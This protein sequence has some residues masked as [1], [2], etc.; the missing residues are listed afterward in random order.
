MFSFFAKLS[1][2]KDPLISVIIPNYNNAPYLEECIDS[3]LDQTYRNKEIIVCDDCSTDDS[4][5]VLSKYRSHKSVRIIY[6]ESN[7]GVSKSRDRAIR[8]SNGEYI[9]TLDSDDYYID[10]NKL[11]NEWN[12][13]SGHKKEGKDVIAFS[14]VKLIL[15]NGRSA[16][17]QGGKQIKQGDLLVPILSREFM[18]PRDFLFSKKSYFAVGG[19]DLDSNLYEDWDLKIRL[20]KKYEFYYT[21][22]LSVVHRITGSGL[23]SQ[24]KAAHKI[25]L[26]KVFQNNIYL[27]NDQKEKE[28][29]IAKF[30]DYMKMYES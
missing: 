15:P 7:M 20:A 3:V 10:K 29:C 6:N 2:S 1:K 27:V 17:F 9:T 8:M 23:S 26:E 12:I 11:Q 18:I 24:S 19:Y 30:K 14:N 25:S 16:K 22:T 21:S 4:R 5:K 13:I 28:H